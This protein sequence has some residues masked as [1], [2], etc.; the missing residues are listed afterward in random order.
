MPKTFDP[1]AQFGPFNRPQGHADRVALFAEWDQELAE[2]AENT[3]N[4]AE[5]LA[6][7]GPAY[8]DLMTRAAACLEARYLPRVRNMDPVTT[9]LSP[10]AEEMRSIRARM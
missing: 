2:M 3:V 10:L 1:Q 6:S 7:D 5:R 9:P 8:R 4:M